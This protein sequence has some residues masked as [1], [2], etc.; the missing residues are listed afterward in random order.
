[1]IKTPVPVTILTGFLGC[2]KT[3]FLNEWIAYNRPRKLAVIENEFG[4]IP[5]DGE[6][7]MN[8]DSNV[9]TLADG[10]LC[11]S[12]SGDMIRL[13]EDLLNQEESFD[14]LMIE[15]TGI[16]DPA[17]IAAPFFADYFLEKHFTLRPSLCLV[18]AAFIADQLHET[19]EA[20][21]QI[22]FADFILI[23]KTDTIAPDYLPQVVALLEG[24]NP[25]ARVFTGFQGHYPM[26]ALEK[27]IAEWSPTQGLEEPLHPHTPNHTH[28][29][30]HTHSTITSFSFILDEPLSLEKMGYFLT[31]MLNVQG[32]QFYRLKGILYVAEQPERIV[33]QSLRTIFSL[34]PA[35]PWQ[36]GETPQTRLVVIGKGIQR[37]SIERI[38]RQCKARQ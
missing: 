34:S 25:T 16:A 12:L 32:H 18:D 4:D 17:G 30:T 19:E 35:A 7:V 31:V 33:L 6:L 22:A 20:R 36:P 38:L 14:E 27:A 3:T 8:A 5:I 21:R 26:Q 13:L 23:N 15:T 1:M 2:G 11:C 9:F 28:T 10:C 24:I 37:E 29:H